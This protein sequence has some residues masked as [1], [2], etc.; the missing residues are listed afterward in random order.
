MNYGQQLIKEAHEKTLFRLVKEHKALS[1]ADLKRITGLSPTTVSSLADNLIA[2]G[3]L[4]ETG[5]KEVKTSGR[6]A[7]LLQVNPSGGHFICSH[8]GKK[9]TSIDCLDLSF[10]TVHHFETETTPLSSLAQKIKETYQYYLSKHE[11]IIAS[12]V[13]MTGIIKNGQLISSTFIDVEGANEL[14]R[15]MREIC[16]EQ[17]IPFFLSNESLFTVYAETTCSDDLKDIISIVVDDGVGAGIL[18]NGHIFTGNEGAAGEFG[19]T[20]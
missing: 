4:V 12:T 18:V 2:K 19:H 15:S 9:I 17:D 8:I 1:R 20:T 11:N 5:I 16:D 3:L 6:K 13:A 10:K 14:T 7:T